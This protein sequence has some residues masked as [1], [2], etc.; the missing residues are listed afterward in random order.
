M[1]G[2]LFFA[3]KQVLAGMRPVL[4]NETLK[5]E[6]VFTQALA[7]ETCM[8]RIFADALPAGAITN[9]QLIAL[10]EAFNAVIETD[11]Y[12]TAF[13]LAKTYYAAWTPY[14]KALS[15]TSNE[16]LQGRSGN[17]NV[18][19]LLHTLSGAQGDRLF[20]YLAHRTSR[21]MIE[22]AG[23][24]HAMIPVI[25]VNH[26]NETVF[27]SVFSNGNRTG[28]KELLDIMEAL[29]LVKVVKGFDAMIASYG[30]EDYMTNL[31]AAY[32]AAHPLESLSEHDRYPQRKA[33]SDEMEWVKTKRTTDLIVVTSKFYQL[34]HVRHDA[35]MRWAL[36]RVQGLIDTTP[37]FFSTFKKQVSRFFGVGAAA[38]LILSGSGSAGHTQP[39]F[40]PSFLEVVIDMPSG[41]PLRGAGFDI[42]PVI[43]ASAADLPSGS[44]KIILSEVARLDADPMPTLPVYDATIFAATAADMVT[45]SGQIILSGLEPLDTN[46]GQLR[47]EDHPVAAF[48]PALDAIGISFGTDVGNDIAQA[49]KVGPAAGALAISN[50]DAEVLKES[51][52][53]GLVADGD[54]NGFVGWEQHQGL[55][56]FQAWDLFQGQHAGFDSRPALGDLPPAAWR[57]A[58]AADLTSGSGKLILKNHARAVPESAITDDQLWN[59]SWGADAQASAEAFFGMGMTL[60]P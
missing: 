53:V 54:T 41:D 38:A 18:G 13:E 23:S 22:E 10:N 19:N 6:I 47:L 32:I 9:N 57:Q 34:A 8:Y 39:F 17:A 2:P 33:N 50:W 21:A 24:K 35:R 12:A 46:E 29:G 20:E 60:R 40:E 59:A 44:G 14:V 36:S 49:Q 1:D 11:D 16:K 25:A 58:E 37:G 45:G 30:Q 7:H 43:A 26:L 15:R 5:S 42:A 27:A 55:A 3:P 28:V 56:E 31:M 51:L 48:T 4:I 52:A